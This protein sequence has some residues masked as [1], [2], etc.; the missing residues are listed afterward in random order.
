MQETILKNGRQYP[1]HPVYCGLLIDCSQQ[2]AWG[3]KA[4]YFVVN[5]L[6]AASKKPEVVKLDIVVNWLI[7]ASKKPEVE[8]LDSVLRW[9]LLNKKKFLLPNTTRQPLTN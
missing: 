5:W 3:W 8:K 6:I 7:A 2:E 4:G 9:I 1:S